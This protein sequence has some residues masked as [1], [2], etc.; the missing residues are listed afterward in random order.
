MP[1]SDDE[2][3]PSVGANVMI[4]FKD[5][6]LAKVHILQ[7]QVAWSAVGELYQEA[8]AK[9]SQ[10]IM[11]VDIAQMKRDGKFLFDDNFSVYYKDVFTK[12]FIPCLVEMFHQKP[13]TNLP[14]DPIEAL[15]LLVLCERLG[16]AM[17]QNSK[18]HLEQLLD[19][20][21]ALDE[22]R[23]A[24]ESMPFR[25]FQASM[26][27][28]LIA[29]PR[30]SLQELVVNRSLEMLITR[31][32]ESLDALG[33]LHMIASEMHRHYMCNRL[34]M[35]T[36][37]RSQEFNSLNRI[38][39]GGTT[40]GK[41]EAE[42]NDENAQRNAEER[43]RLRVER[44]A[45]GAERERLRVEVSK[46]EAAKQQQ[47]RAQVSPRNGGGGGSQ[48]NSFAVNSTF[49]SNGAA[50]GRG[51]CNNGNEGVNGVLAMRQGLILFKIGRQSGNRIVRING[52]TLEWRK[53]YGSYTRDHS[54]SQRD[55][56][57]VKTTEQHSFSIVH[58]AG[59]L[60]FR[61]LND[62][63]AALFAQAVDHW[64]RGRSVGGA[65]AM[66]NVRNNNA[67]VTMNRM[68]V[69]ASMTAPMASMNHASA[70]FQASTATIPNQNHH[71]QQAGTTA[72]GTMINRRF[73]R[74]SFN[75]PA[76][77]SGPLS[78][79]ATPPM[80]RSTAPLDLSFGSTDS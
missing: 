9:E 27:L 35:A 44:E 46:W 54:V 19:R 4:Y 79:A 74:M 38:Q 55:V 23:N 66:D 73:S 15:R 29:P 76:P 53:E 10:G 7:L 61:A 43:E 25:M 31:L 21:V 34:F 68:S 52:D 72:N 56:I 45:L 47:A 2:S 80:P 33:E 49:R 65:S 58:K 30:S 75:R 1:R 13:L 32:P 14:S 71:Q 63:A 16:A 39:G 69:A 24:N 6:L 77:T 5:E 57:N 41:R 12:R 59:I 17:K 11:T 26:D 51:E 60:T 28:D 37:K 67:S 48:E 42:K 18:T 64:M 8:A 3:T 50:G 36:S 62:Q 20:S 70:T 22:N 40:A 78:A